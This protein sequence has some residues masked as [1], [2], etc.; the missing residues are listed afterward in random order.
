MSFKEINL[1]NFLIADL[2]KNVLIETTTT[3]IV[4]AKSIEKTEPKTNTIAI[5]QKIESIQFLG[6]NKKNITIVINDENAVHIEDEKLEFITKMFTA[7]KLTIADV[8]IV[9]INNKHILHSQIAQ[10]LQPCFVLLFDVNTK[11]I[12]LPI[13]VT[14]YKIET[15]NNC[16]I[17]FVKDLKHYLGNTEADKLEKSKLWLCLKQLFIQ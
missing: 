5:P 17:L 12:A 6:E 11:Q 8:A 3:P 4:V 9:N 10:Q 16:E 15:Y 13:M 1:P 2:Y 14:E 7:C